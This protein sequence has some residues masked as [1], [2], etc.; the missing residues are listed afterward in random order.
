MLVRKP[1]INTLTAHR[2]KALFEPLL[3]FLF[4]PCTGGDITFPAREP[5]ESLVW[6]ISPLCG[7]TG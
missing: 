6:F 5:M 3:I 2:E 4:F 1:P 7:G